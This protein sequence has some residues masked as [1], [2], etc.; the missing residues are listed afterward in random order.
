MFWNDSRLLGSEWIE[1]YDE[2]SQKLEIL[3]DYDVD[4]F[5]ISTKSLEKKLLYINFVYNQPV[6][7]I[8]F[9]WNCVNL[10]WISVARRRSCPS[11]WFAVGGNLHDYLADT[12]QWLRSLYI[13]L[14]T[15]RSAIA[16]IIV[17]VSL[18]AHIIIINT[19]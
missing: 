5:L 14:A 19:D 2:K 10:E 3:G 12:Q 6:S 18:V 4:E 11:H 9:N 8:R 16:S 13:F 1:T 15:Y 17:A 7:E